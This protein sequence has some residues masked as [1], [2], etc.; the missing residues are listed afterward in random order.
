MGA[1]R[2]AIEEIQNTT[3]RDFIAEKHGSCQDEDENQCADD[4]RRCPNHRLGEAVGNDGME[5]R[6]QLVDSLLDIDGEDNPPPPYKDKVSSRSG[7][8][9]TVLT[10]SFGPWPPSRPQPVEKASWMMACPLHTQDMIDEAVTAQRR[11]SPPLPL[12]TNLNTPQYLCICITMTQRTENRTN[13]PS[14]HCNAHG[15]K[16]KPLPPP[17]PHISIFGILGASRH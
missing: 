6:D 10:L 5:K 13:P 8:F 15:N 11:R 12:P 16:G 3:T 7:N 9:S 17:G 1:W 14:L 2:L 4:D